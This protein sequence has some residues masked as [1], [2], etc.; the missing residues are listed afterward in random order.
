MKRILIFSLAY[1]P[2]VGGAEVAIKEITDRIPEIEWHMITLRFAGE[3]RSERVGGVMVHRIGNG[4]SYLSKILFVPSA[5]FA[6]MKLNRQYRFDGVWAMMTYMLFPLV[7][8]KFVGV[9][10]PYALTLQD[11]DPFE[12]VFKRWHIVPFVPLIRVGFR[13]ARVV[14]AL[15]T[16]L[17]AWA[18]SVG[19]TK[20]VIIV[21]N[22]A[23]VAHFSKSTP[24]DIGRKEGDVWLVTS[25]RLVYKNAVDQVLRALPLL[26]PH[27]KFLILG[28]GPEES[29]LR[30][31]AGELGITNRVQFEGYVSHDALPSYLHA[32]DIFIRPSRTE[33]FGASFPEAMAAGLPVIATQV[34]G[35]SDFLF[36]K[37]K[38]PSMP[39]TGW[40]V[41]V[42]SPEEIAA[43]VTAIL[44]DPVQTEK[45][46]AEA[47][48]MV[49]EKYDWSTI[50]RTML[51][52]VFVLL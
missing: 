18:R 11:G 43:Q 44:G 34:G 7:L 1:Y 20:E 10:V 12:R 8:L 23:D 52:K 46:C 27:I 50:A 14:T 21:P 38:N 4:S 26:P 19:Y 24:R 22:G 17:A 45:V 48:R 49:V 13:N 25:S 28:T 41:A 33:G 2:H 5:A 31:L 15:S 30:A 9:R 6:Y 39:T 32:C 29:A 37:V 40:A 42:D 35:I 51:E 47:R 36:D 16:Y 3:S